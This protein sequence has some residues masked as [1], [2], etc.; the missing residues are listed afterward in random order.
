M[1]EHGIVTH[2]VENKNEG[3]ST[4]FV[5]SVEHQVVVL[6]TPTPDRAIKRDTRLD[7]D[8]KGNDERGSTDGAANSGVF[9]SPG[10]KI[11]SKILKELAFDNPG[12]ATEACF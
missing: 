4:G 2:A 12:P 3:E 6:D 10:K 9:P 7:P 8:L 1:G 11:A 5:A